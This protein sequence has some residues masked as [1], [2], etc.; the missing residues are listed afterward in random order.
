M[1]KL[2]NMPGVAWLVIGVCVTALLMPTAAFAAGAL[3]FTGV[4]GTSGNRADVTPS[5][6]LQTNSQL[7][8]TTGSHADVSA[9]GQL[10]TA[11]A[12]ASNFF[13]GQASLPNATSGGTTLAPM[14]TPPTG[15][16]AIVTSAQ[17]AY[18]NVGSLINDPF[19]LFLVSSNP[20]CAVNQVSSFGEADPSTDGE[21]TFSLDPGIVIPAGDTLCLQAIALDADG[22]VEGYTVP[23][24]DVPAATNSSAEPLKH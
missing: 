13:H 16:A 15:D 10:L 24:S 5:G 12:D 21:S 3:K 11:S 6:Q 20:S 7:Q 4:Q 17:S 8:G 19:T 14:Y 22:A 9:S 23:A 2:K 1:T 18:W